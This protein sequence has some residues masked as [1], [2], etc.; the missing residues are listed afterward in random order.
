MQ[1]DPHADL[2]AVGAALRR[3]LGLHGALDRERRVA[4]AHGMVLVRDRGAE[5]RHDA[6]T[7]D[8]VD[9]A[10][11]AMHGVHHDAER[12]VQDAPRVLR[13]DVLDQRERAFDVGEQHRDLLALALQRRAR[14]QDAF[15]QMS[16]RAGRDRWPRRGLACRIQLGDRGEQL[17]AVAERGDPELL[18]VVRRERAQD[19]GV[20]VV[21]RE[22]LGV[23]AEA[24]VLQPGADV[25]RPSRMSVRDHHSGAVRDWRANSCRPKIRLSGGASS[26]E[27]RVALVQEA[28]CRRQPI[29]SGP[30]FGCTFRR[31]RPRRA[32]M[33]DT[34]RVAAEPGLRPICRVV[35]RPRDRSRG[36]GRADRRP[37]ERAGPA[38]RPSRQAA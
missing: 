34:G 15:G 38:A 28:Q 21:R 25:H 6:I 13:I 5:Q 35:R 31:R 30:Y 9:R 14:A 24:V 36:V 8:P 29:G 10:F 22:C 7:Q 11:V 20:D 1:A 3:G 33:S 19:L 27:V 4:G 23:L 12:R 37:S 26:A 2:D 32:I 16:G 17:L 18:Q